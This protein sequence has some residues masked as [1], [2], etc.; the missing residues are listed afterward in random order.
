MWRHCTAYLRLLADNHR[1][2]N[3]GIAEPERGRNGGIAGGKGHAAERRRELVEV[4]ADL[5]NG[6]VFRFGQ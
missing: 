1:L 2:Q 3:T 4:V 6:T 5:V